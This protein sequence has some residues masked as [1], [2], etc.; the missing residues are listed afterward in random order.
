MYPSLHVFLLC[1]SFLFKPLCASV[2]G[3]FGLEGSVQDVQLP[4]V[5]ASSP[6]LSRLEGLQAGNWD[7]T[8]VPWAAAAEHQEPLGST[9]PPLPVG[10][11]VQPG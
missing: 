7:S 4:E 2:G 6:E 11:C 10:P 1:T 8:G 9:R 3:G 5:Q